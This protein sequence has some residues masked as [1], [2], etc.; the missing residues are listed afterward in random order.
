M[1]KAHTTVL[2]EKAVDLLEVDSNENFIDCTAGE[3]GHSKEILKRNG[4]NGKVLGFEWDRHMYDRL[5]KEN[6]DRLELINKSYVFLKEVV[7]NNNFKP[8]SGVLLDLGMSTWHIKESGKGFTFQEE[9]PLDMRYN[10]DSLLTA[11]EVVN[12][13]KEDNLAKIIRDYS[14]ERYSKEIAKEIVRSRPLETTKDL[15]K[16]IRRAVP[17]D[18]EKGRIHPATRTFQAI[19]IVVN[20]ELNNLKEVLPQAFDVLEPGGRI[21]VISFHYLEDEEVERFFTKKEGLEV[22]KTVTPSDQEVTENP[23]SRS[24]ILRVAKKINDK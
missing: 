4:P 3:G 22:V 13:W 24:A 5:K 19:R 16:A 9:E 6:I 8:V 12:H 10:T 18:Y 15:V 14:D 7:E 21:V 17:N 11:K 1:E 20:A 2:K 23:S